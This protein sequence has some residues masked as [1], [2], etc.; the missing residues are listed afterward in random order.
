MLDFPDIAALNEEMSPK[1]VHFFAEDVDITLEN[2]ATLKT[3][4]KKMATQEGKPFHG[5]SYI[6]C[7]DEYLHK[8]NVEHL[9]HDDYTDVITFPYATDKVQGD[10]FISTER[11]A[12][13][14]LLHQVTF[15]NEL[16]RILIHGALHLCGYTDKTPEDKE[17]MTAKEN[18]YLAKLT[19]RKKS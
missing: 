5:I 2:K 10:I 13:N 18:F 17:L 15:E 3:W 14:A 6:F 4:I 8:I 7:S 11:V 9:A 16:H 19:F 12:E 1:G